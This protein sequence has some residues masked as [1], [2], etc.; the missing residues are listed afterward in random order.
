M[1]T[2]D[3]ETR[4]TADLIMW[5]AQRY[6]HDASTQVL[7]LAWAFDDEE[8]VHLWHRSHPWIA[9]SKRPDELIERIRDG[10]IVEAH[11][12]A[13][14]YY[15]WN[16][17]LQ[18]E[19]PEF[20]APIKLEQ[21]RC[22]AAKVS[23]MSLPRALGDAVEAVKLPHK[24]MAEGR[25]LIQKL[26]KP[27]AKRKNMGFNEDES[28]HHRNWEYCKSDVRAERG[29]SGYCP[30]MSEQE[31]EY[32]RMDFRTNDR[33]I[34][35]DLDAA[36]RGLKMA[37]AEGE[38][39]NEELQ[40]ITDGMVESFTKRKS[41]LQW[42]NMRL[43][44]LQQPLVENT[45]ADTFSFALYGVP[46]K[47][48][49][50]AKEALKPKMDAHWDS[51]GPQGAGVKRVMEIAMEGNK[52]SVAKYRRMIESVCPDGR[53]HDIMLYNGADRTGRW[54]G[55]GV[56]PHN[57]VSGY[58]KEMP[59]VWDDLKK[60]D[61]DVVTLIWGEPMVALAK[62]CRGALTASP[63]KVLYA[64]DFNA[65]E[66][67]KLAWL[68]GCTRLLD[69]FQT[70]G[71]PYC[72][73]ASAIYNRPITKKDKAER[74]MGKQAILGL[75]YAMG[76][77]KFQATVWMNEGIW[78][79]DEFCQMIVKLYRQKMYPEVPALWKASDAAACRAVMEGGEHYCGGNELGI[80]GVSYFVDRDFLHCRLPSG[81]LLAYL[82]PEVHVRRNYRFKARNKKGTVTSIV[83]PVKRDGVQMFKIRA[84][85]EKLAKKADKILLPDAPETFEQ[86]HLSFM[87]RDTYTRQWKRCG[88][89]G[90]TLVEN[91]DQA[92]SRDL[93]AESL[94]RVDEM[95]GFDLLLSI[96][97][98][99]VAE[100]REGA[101]TLGEFEAVV[102]E[103][104]EWA[105]GMPISAEGWIGERLR[106]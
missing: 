36:Q 92:S 98:E 106:K 5:G 104:P 53:L 43:Q 89:H 4:S 59:D 32:W 85:A 62:A 12:A 91:Y 16:I 71:D 31:L 102:A 21:L 22:S 101:C 80:G 90:G 70:G 105:P 24:K 20:N 61:P 17:A 15:I 100:A 7:C 69:L 47:A 86:P 44:E 27:M 39:L 40:Q 2:L 83:F 50:A 46:T 14:E 45:R 81:R 3:F 54:S 19:F 68:S 66:A 87:G 82:Y 96:H 63:G 55:K 95:D 67:R 94:R 103:V 75:G 30:D 73:M 52:S 97:D 51:L 84:H 64:A 26:S 79:E 42:L 57:F 60:L 41:L 8:E 99:V 6:A 9:K 65:I 58:A 76:W 13:F 18:R 48:A 34:R 28:L 88:T 1:I 77:E 33:G 29:L 35:L 11:N 56:Q 23:C 72:D 93:L 37:R 38:R 10:E 78:L 74:Q 25:S 49:D